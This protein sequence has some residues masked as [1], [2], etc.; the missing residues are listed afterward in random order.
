MKPISPD[1]GYLEPAGRKHDDTKI[2]NVAAAAVLTAEA[3]P[4]VE[5]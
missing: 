1:R 5:I 3:A 4:A 2:V